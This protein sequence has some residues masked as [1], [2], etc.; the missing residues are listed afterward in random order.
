MTDPKAIPNAKLELKG[1]ENVSYTE[2]V[3]KAVEGAHA[4]LL[5]TE[6]QQYKNLDFKKIFSLMEKPSTFFDTR[7]IL[8]HKELFEIGFNVYPVGKKPLTH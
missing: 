7:N 1:V 5:M 6:W 2:D 3:Y 8:D 4:V